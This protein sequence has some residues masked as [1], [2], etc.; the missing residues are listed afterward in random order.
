M[1]VADLL[2]RFAYHVIARREATK[3]SSRR[4]IEIASGLRPR[5]DSFGHSDLHMPIAWSNGH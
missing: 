5:N 2:A 3:Q 4:N 1:R